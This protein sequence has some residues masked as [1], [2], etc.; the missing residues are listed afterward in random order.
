MNRALPILLAFTL[1]VTSCITVDSQTEAPTEI[2]FVTSTLPP[3]RSLVS[4]ATLTP[5]GE[6]KATPTLELTIPANC[7]VVAVLIE[8]VTI[9]DGTRLPA[10]KSFTKTWKF[11]NTGTCPWV[12]YTLEFVSGDRMGAPESAP[13]SQTPAG[14]FVNVS[15]DLAAPTADGLYTGFFELRD[16]EGEV[17]PIGLEKTFWVKIGVGVGELPVS[18]SAVP[19]STAATPGG[20]G[21]PAGT[22]DCQA[23]TNAGFISE[24]LALINAARAEAGVPKLALN[25]QL[26][27]AA[28]RH[29]LD[30]ACNNLISHTGSDGSSIGQRIAAAGYSPSYYL[31]I[32]AIGGPQDAMSQWMGEALHRNAVLDRNVS[33]IGI[34]Y[35]FNPDGL[36]GGHFTV[37][38]ASP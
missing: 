12:G 8:D 18:T 33:E 34:G 36:Y 29:S 3:T 6:A 37:V 19:A 38:M 9:P 1:L 7:K 4:R 13:V 31:E 16:A 32:I 14:E 23:S 24:L 15:V 22:G 11:K 10:G 27:E 26:S 2:V 17:V 28:Q 30:T 21:E 5:T 35:A 20:D 25:A